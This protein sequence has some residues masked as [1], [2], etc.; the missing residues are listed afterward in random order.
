M[1]KEYTILTASGSKYEFVKDV[2]EYAGMEYRTDYR[3]NCIK[4]YSITPV[5]T[6]FEEDCILTAII[7][8]ATAHAHDMDY[9]TKARE[10]AREYV[11]G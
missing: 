8:G 11:N 9:R 6:N 2:C 4:C 3:A 5:A 1:R 10:M 7:L